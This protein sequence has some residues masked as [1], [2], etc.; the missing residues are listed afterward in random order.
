M[1]A[2]TLRRAEVGGCE[3]RV[4]PIGESVMVG[5]SIRAKQRVSAAP[6]PFFVSFSETPDFLGGVAP[7][8]SE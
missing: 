4:N 2:E 6:F 7:R 8:I 1:S 3:E 5:K